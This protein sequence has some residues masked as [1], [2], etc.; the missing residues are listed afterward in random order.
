MIKNETGNEGEQ[1]ESKCKRYRTCRGFEDER[2]DTR[3]REK[4]APNLGDDILAESEVSLAVLASINLAV[5]AHQEESTHLVSR[6]Q[7]GVKQTNGP[8]TFVESLPLFFLPLL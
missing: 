5:Q 4:W 2:A 3:E 6:R 8:R 7:P 1:S